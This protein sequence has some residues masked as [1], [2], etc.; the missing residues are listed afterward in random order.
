MQAIGSSEETFRLKRN[1]GEPARERLPGTSDALR[2][3][4]ARTNGQIPSAKEAGMN[5]LQLLL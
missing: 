5:H 4:T 3:L 2:I 1:A